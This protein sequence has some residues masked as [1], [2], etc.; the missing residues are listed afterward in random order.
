MKDEYGEAVV[1]NCDHFVSKIMIFFQTKR[2]KNK[3]TLMDR[4][5]NKKKMLI[6]VLMKF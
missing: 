6:Y 2:Y 1:N 3:Y 5:L 4:Y